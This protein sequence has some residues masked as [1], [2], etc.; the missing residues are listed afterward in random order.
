MILIT[1]ICEII[2]LINKI[3]LL[4]YTYFDFV[5]YFEKL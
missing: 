5:G 2:K 4:K 1:Y 3:D